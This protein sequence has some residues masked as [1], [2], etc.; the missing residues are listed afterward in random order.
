M[1]QP[2][3][4]MKVA[5]NSGAKEVLVIRNLGGSLHKFSHLGQLVVCTVKKAQPR[6]L[7]AKG[8]V[9]RGVIVRTRR[10]TRRRD[11]SYISFSDNAVVLVKPDR[12]PLASRVFGAIANEVR[13]AGFAKIISLAPEV[14]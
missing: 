4:R 3:T 2:E 14:I 6:G 5:D 11:G 1:I 12:S 7:V 8:T 10:M 9:V 13:K